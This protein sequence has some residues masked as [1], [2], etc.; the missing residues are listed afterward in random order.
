MKKMKS[1]FVISITAL[2]MLCIPAYVIMSA[3]GNV[4]TNRPESPLSDI[5]TT[6]TFAQRMTSYEINEF[7]A[8][9]NIYVV[10]LEGRGIDPDGE[11]ATSVVR[12]THGVDYAEQVIIRMA[13]QRDVEFVGFISMNALVCAG[14]LDNIQADARVFLADTSGDVRLQNDVNRHVRTISQSSSFPESLA[15]ELEDLG[16]VQ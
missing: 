2:A 12:T 5:V 4:G 10:K 3:R 15:W 11:C 7:V 1:V 13:E 6:I 16:L 14:E 8:L 9:H